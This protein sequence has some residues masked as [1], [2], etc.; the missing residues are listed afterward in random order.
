[1]GPGG[2]LKIYLAVP[3]LFLYLSFKSA[4]QAQTDS[5]DTNLTLREGKGR[6]MAKQLRFD[7]EARQK[8]LHGVEKM[9]TAVKVTLG[10][11]GRNVVLDKKFGAPRSPTTG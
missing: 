8:L 10:P 11:K 5:R 3:D 6:D 9:S 1:V 7:E 2:F 4:R